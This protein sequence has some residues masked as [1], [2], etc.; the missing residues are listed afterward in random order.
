MTV[1]SVVVAPL[2]AGHL[3]LHDTDALPQLLHLL[4]QR[5]VLHHAPPQ[6]S[7]S[8]DYAPSSKQ[9]LC[10]GCSA[11]IMSLCGKSP[12]RREASLTSQVKSYDFEAANRKLALCRVLGCN[13]N[14]ARTIFGAIASFPHVSS[15]SI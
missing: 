1:P 13:H 8:H 2:Q 7:A 10:A 12:V 3:L 11:T 5:H 4:L 14:I 9:A 15:P 6:V